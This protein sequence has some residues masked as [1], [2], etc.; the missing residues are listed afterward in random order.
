MNINK[1]LR[2]KYWVGPNPPP[3]PPPPLP[4]S[5]M[6][7]PTLSCWGRMREELVDYQR[8]HAPCGKQS[9]MF[10]TCVLYI[11]EVHLPR[12]ATPNETIV[13]RPDLSFYMGAGGLLPLPI[14]MNLIISTMIRVGKKQCLL[15]ASECPHPGTV[16]HI[17]TISVPL[18]LVTALC[19]LLCESMY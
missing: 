7:C 2:V 4:G 19:L 16:E 9:G 3:P 14:T 8:I 1:V 12:K 5:S 15:I 10:A 6:I 18:N 17:H 11:G 13:S